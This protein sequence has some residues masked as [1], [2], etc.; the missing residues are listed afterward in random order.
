MPYILSLE[1]LHSGLLDQAGHKSVQLSDLLTASA[2]VSEKDGILLY[3]SILAREYGILAVI[4]I[5]GASHAI[6]TGQVI[7]V[8][9]DRGGIWL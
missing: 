2:I 3:G 4:S 8:D 6:Q 7:T 1:E 5:A 9:G